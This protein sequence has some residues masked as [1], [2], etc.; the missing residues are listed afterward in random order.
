MQAIMDQEYQEEDALQVYE[1]RRALFHQIAYELFDMGLSDRDRIVEVGATDGDFDFFLRAEE[2]WR[3]LYVPLGAPVDS[4]S[5]DDWASSIEADFFVSINLLERISQP[6]TLMALMAIRARKGVVA[7][8]LNPE[9]LTEG[10]IV[11]PISSDDFAI[12][13]WDARVLSLGGREKDSIIATYHE[14]RG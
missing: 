8:V 12:H 6:F 7:V 9:P 10:K 2:E 3:G 1:S 11:T 14:A 4:T 13:G 5:F